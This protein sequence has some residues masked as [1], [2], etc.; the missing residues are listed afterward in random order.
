MKV[1]LLKRLRAKFVVEYFPSTKLYKVSGDRETYHSRKQEAVSQKECN[2][3][4]YGR[5]HYQ[6]YSKRVI[7]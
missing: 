7:I 1:K 3:L 2:I 4:N 5:K 6:K